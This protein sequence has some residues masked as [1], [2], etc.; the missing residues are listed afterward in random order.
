MEFIAFPQ[1]EWNA[2]N[3]LGKSVAA[4]DKKCLQIIEKIKEAFEQDSLLGPGAC[5][6]IIGESAHEL[7]L[8]QSPVGNGRVLRCWSSSGR[9]LLGALMFQRE[10]F[11]K[12]DVRYWET[13]WGITVPLY[14][15]AYS[16][17][18][19]TAV[20]FDFGGYFGNTKNVAFTAA[21]SILAGLVN[22]PE[23]IT[24]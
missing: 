19:P 18:G 24:M 6:M 17:T 9:E 12:Y 11:D 3:Q 22:G 7:A 15:D 16:G 10:Q 20:H 21:I 14:E 4:I 8:I 13:V 23:R 2:F 5:S 1:N